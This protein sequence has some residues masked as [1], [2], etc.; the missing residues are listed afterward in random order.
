MQRV[1]ARF[2]L[3]KRIIYYNLGGAPGPPGNEA[4]QEKVF[5]KRG[6]S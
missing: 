6:L 3:I 1:K 2:S 4:A 5:F